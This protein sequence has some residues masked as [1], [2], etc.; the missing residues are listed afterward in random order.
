[1]LQTAPLPKYLLWTR[2]QRSSIHKTNVYAHQIPPA[3][4]HQCYAADW[5]QLMIAFRPFFMTAF[6]VRP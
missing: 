6:P 2:V 5:F 1:M 4:I 3:T